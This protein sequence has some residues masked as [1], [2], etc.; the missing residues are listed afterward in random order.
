MNELDNIIILIE[1]EMDFYSYEDFYVNAA[2]LKKMYDTIDIRTKK[3][4]KWYVYSREINYNLKNRIWDYLNNNISLG[5]F[6]EYEKTKK[7]KTKKKK[8]KENK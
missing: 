2:A 3:L 5:S 1:N 6:M 8:R 4:Y 7:K